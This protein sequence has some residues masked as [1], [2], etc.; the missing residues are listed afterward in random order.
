MPLVNGLLAPTESLPVLGTAVPAKIPAEK[1]NL[2]SA[3][4]GSAFGGTSLLIILEDNP[5]PPNP[6]YSLGVSSTTTFDSERLIRIIFAIAHT[7]V[8]LFSVKKFYVFL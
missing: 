4:R 2:F 7:S 3:P 5:L 1:I 8:K 6:R